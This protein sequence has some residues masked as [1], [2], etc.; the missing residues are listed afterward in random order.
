MPS[1]EQSPHS[2]LRQK[3][4]CSGRC[5]HAQCCC[6]V[7]DDMDSCRSYEESAPSVFRAAESSTVQME[8]VRSTES[9]SITYKAARCH[10]QEDGIPISCSYF[11]TLSTEQDGVAM[12]VSLYFPQIL[13][14][15]PAVLTKR[16]CG[17]YQTHTSYIGISHRL[18]YHHPRNN[19][20]TSPTKFSHS[21]VIKQALNQT[22]LCR[23]HC[24]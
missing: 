13:A 4:R 6:P 23:C 5:C 17:F 21:R 11:L 20:F 2:S 3:V 14:G 12:T 8:S 22:T 18:C 24:I 19:N 9:T 16:F 7:S 15:A 10:V 1:I